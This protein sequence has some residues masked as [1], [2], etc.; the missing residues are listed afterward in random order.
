LAVADTRAE[1]I[2]TGAST[3]ALRLGKSR[4]GNCSTPPQAGLSAEY[5]KT[6]ALVTVRLLGAMQITTNAGELRSGLR[7]SAR[8]LLAY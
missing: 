1:P 8:E 3:K 2:M 7:A 5:G 4:S 6:Q